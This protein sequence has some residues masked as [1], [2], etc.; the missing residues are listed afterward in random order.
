[1]AGFAYATGRSM[2]A[3]ESLALATACGAANC[4][5]DSPGA[6]R[7]ADIERFRDRVRA[8]MLAVPW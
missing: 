7:L 1:V 3:K 6:A 8:E 2:P 4:L 5:A